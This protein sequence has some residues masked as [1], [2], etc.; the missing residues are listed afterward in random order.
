LEE[1]KLK[2]EITVF[3]GVL[4]LVGTVVGASAFI[5]IGPLAAKT[6]PTLWLAYALAAIP[7]VF[8]A[9]VFAQLGTAFPMTGATYITTS[10]L[11]S[12]VVSL[13]MAWSVLLGISLFVLPLM[14][15]GVGIYLKAMLPAM[16]DG[17]LA[18]L[19]I[20]LV[21]LISL[22]FFT[23][24]N[25]IGIKWMMWFQSI[26]TGLVIIVLLVFGLGGSFFANH[27]YQTP[28][29]PLGLGTLAA[30]IIPAYIMYT[31]VNAMTE[32]GGETKNPK[33][34]IPLIL[35]ISMIL[36]L[37][38][39]VSI[40]YSLTGLMPWQ[41]LKADSV[42]PAMGKF[43]PTTF[44]LYFASIGAVLAAITT[45]IGGFAFLARDAMALGRDLV[46]PE[47]FGRVSKR[48][49]T[50]A[51]SIILLGS[52]SVFG[53]FLALGYLLLTNSDSLIVE[54]AT[55]ASLAFMLMSILGCLSMFLLRGKMPDRYQAATFKLK[56]FWLPFFTIGGAVIFTVLMIIGFISSPIA[57]AAILM[58][59]ITGVIYYYLRRWQLKRRGLRLED[60]LSKVEEI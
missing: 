20:P 12:P 43:L 38:I 6:G 23:W 36:L 21:A 19:F 40:T 49:G 55:S 10:R 16:G 4:L 58:L 34:S 29:F 25:I 46:F 50:P 44:A 54:L 1:G 57:G 56:G 5:L 45:L 22:V 35:M 41:E 53:L 15:L 32:L 31:G 14:G 60:R 37:I 24:L 52:I 7:A 11:I 18:Q 9:V 30:A 48:Y 13:V 27:S 2:R 33:K 51:N 28:M 3:H 26:A 8:V 17:I 59:I 47:V 39:Y 42:A